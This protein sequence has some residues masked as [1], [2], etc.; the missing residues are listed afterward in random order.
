LPPDPKTDPAEDDEVCF[1]EGG[2]IFAE[3]VEKQMAILPE[4][5]TIEDS[6]IY[7]V[8]LR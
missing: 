5:V 2:D 7:R 3:D 8:Q 6:S 4:V 1:H